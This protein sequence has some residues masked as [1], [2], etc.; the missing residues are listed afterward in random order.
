MVYFCP[1]TD[2]QYMSGVAPCNTVSGAMS[3]KMSSE[4]NVVTPEDWEALL[5][6]ITE[7]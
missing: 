6:L 7:S 2:K 1:S 4:E 5:P 3:W